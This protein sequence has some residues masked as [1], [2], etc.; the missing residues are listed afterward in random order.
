MKEP[1]MMRIASRVMAAAFALLFLTQCQSPTPARGTADRAPVLLAIFAHPDD[2]ASVAPVLAKYASEGVKV[3][4]AVATDG[5]LGVA[6]HAGFVAGDELAAARTKELQC[7][8]DKLGL[9]PPILFGLHDQLKMG[10]GLPAHG[11]QLH[12]LRERV[13]RLFAELRPDAVITWPASGWTGHPDHRLV[14]SMVTEVFQSRYRSQPAQLYYPG[15]PAG[16]LPESHPTAGAGM[17]PRLLTVEIAVTPHDYAKA[18][19]AWLC[20]R[21]QYTPEQIEQLYQSLVGAQQGVAHFM[22]LTA[23]TRK[24]TSLLTGAAPR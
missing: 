22:P 20:H 8:A 19:E 10:E 24:S 14:N 6:P 4:L 16:R 3:Y 15:V 17:D 18:K 11:E 13:Q 12:Q 2:E 21:S 1:L 9:H 7:A 23:A 5:R